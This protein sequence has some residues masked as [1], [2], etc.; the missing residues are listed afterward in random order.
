MGRRDEALRLHFSEHPLRVCDIARDLPCDGVA[1]I[2]LEQV[3]R[4]N[5]ALSSGCAEFQGRVVLRKPDPPPA[6]ADQ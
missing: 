3:L 4:S 1:G 6:P 5:N 2:E